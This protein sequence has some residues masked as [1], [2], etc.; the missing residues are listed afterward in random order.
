MCARCPSPTPCG[1]GLGPTNPELTNIVLGTLRFSATMI[2]TSFLATYPDIL[3][4]KRS[5][6]PYGMPSPH[7]ERSPTPQKIPEDL[8]QT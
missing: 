7:L 4:S 2:L 8:M 5:S 1:L 3:A 6:T